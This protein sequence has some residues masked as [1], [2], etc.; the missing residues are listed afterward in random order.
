MTDPT[1]TAKPGPGRLPEPPA[2][3]SLPPEARAPLAAFAGKPPPAPAWFTAALAHQPERLSV[4][5]PRGAL[6]VLAWGERG[7]PG[8]L[9]SHGSFASADWWSFIAP[10]FA[11]DYRVAAVS[12]AGMGLSDWRDAYNFED[13]TDDAEAA[14]Q[15]AGLYADGGKPIYVGQSFSGGLALYA[16]THRPE[17][18]S[19]AILVD[20]NFRSPAAQALQAAMDQAAAR[21]KAPPRG[22]PDLET[23]VS[24][25][26]L[27]PA[28]TVENLYVLDH[29]ARTS[30]RPIPAPE[31]GGQV[32]AW[33]YDP[34][35]MA[36]VDYAERIAFFASR[37][38]VR[39]PIAHIY[40]DLSRISLR[41]EAAREGPFPAGGLEVGVPQAD[42]HIVIDQPLALVGALRGVLA[43]WEAGRA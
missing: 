15:A 32:W 5:T 24:K 34:A 23:A 30:F 8:L 9:L 17:Q 3:E 28:Q 33:K 39:R 35:F 41:G 10:F 36:K 29:I 22:F 16:A 38:Q 31:G 27:L 4:A 26:R 43:C 18:L 6:E 40:G 37:P 7:K 11:A 1:T 14:A 13:T 2:L 42:H 20:A 25:F 21:G 19:G 12:L